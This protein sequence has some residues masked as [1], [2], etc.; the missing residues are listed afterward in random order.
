MGHWTRLALALA[1]PFL[2]TSCFVTPGKFTATLSINADRSFAFTYVGEVISMDP[3][4]SFAKGMAEG[5][6]EG[7]SDEESDEPDA[8]GATFHAIQDTDEDAAKKAET[9]AKNRAVAEALKKE[10]GFRRVDYLGDGK[11]MIDYAIESRLTHN[12]SFPINSDAQ[13]IFPFILLELRQGG[14]VRMTAPAFANNSS[15]GAPGGEQ[16]AAHLDGTFTLT[17]DAEIV[18]QN[19]EDGAK[20]AGA[21][22]T[23]TWR[24]T[25]LSKAAPMAVLKL[26]P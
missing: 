18:S 7:L 14:T 3:G 4:E 16:A 6:S 23:I 5:L 20:V 10:A 11:F 21:K 2:L 8:D 12:Y 17:T 19:N 9:E 15:S 26:A 1:A 24:A 25:P 22:R 13:M